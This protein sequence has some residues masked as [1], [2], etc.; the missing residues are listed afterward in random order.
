VG[1]LLCHLTSGKYPIG[2]IGNVCGFQPFKNDRLESYLTMWSLYGS[3]LFEPFS[4]LIA[5]KPQ[6][7]DTAA[8]THI[9][10]LH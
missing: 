2:S 4:A 7:A 5:A 8:G 9:Y 10:W 3:F 6:P 1:G